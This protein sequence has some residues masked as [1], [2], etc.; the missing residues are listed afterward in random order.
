LL[1]GVRLALPELGADAAHDGDLAALADEARRVLSGAAPEHEPNPVRALLAVLAV[2]V[3]RH[4]DARERVPTRR[5]P[6]L[7]IAAETTDTHPAV[8]LL[9]SS[10]RLPF[11][12]HVNVMP[13]SNPNHADARTAT[14]DVWGRLG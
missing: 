11:L 5:V 10:I 2:A 12:R 13:A 9:S 3:H 4:Q 14:R 1:A 6:Q 8:H 7:D